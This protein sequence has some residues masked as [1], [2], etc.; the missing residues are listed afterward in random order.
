M[1]IFYLC[2][3]MCSYYIILLAV[4][5]WS[6]WTLVMLN[7]STDLEASIEGSIVLSLYSPLSWFYIHWSGLFIIRNIWPLQH[8]T[9]LLE[10]IVQSFT[11]MVGPQW[12]WPCWRHWGE[13]QT[14]PTQNRETSPRGL[15]CV[16]VCVPMCI[17]CVC[18]CLSMCI[19]VCMYVPI[20]MWYFWRLKE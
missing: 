5:R 11:Y 10:R 1:S 7:N 13:L 15:V 14:V 20:L 8:L 9:V 12:Y 19:S 17:K 2:N 3:N 18:V 16:F 4:A 6:E